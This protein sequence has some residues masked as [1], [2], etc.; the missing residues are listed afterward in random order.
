MSI[1]VDQIVTI[2]ISIVTGLG[3]GAVIIWALSSWLGKVWAN[4][5]LEKDRLRYS[6]ELEVVKTELGRAS[7]EYLIKF[8]SLHAERGTIIRDLYK[9]LMSAQ[10]LVESILKR[11]QAEGEPRLEDKIKDFVDSFNQFYQFYLDS[12]IYFPPHLC[13]QIED[14]AKKLREIHIDITLYPVSPEDIQ[15]KVAPEL[16]KE[17]REFWE[18]AR[19]TFA[20]EAEGLF[21][22]IEAEI[23]DLLGVE[24]K[25]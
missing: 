6:R 25:F 7:Q 9:K 22:S 13:K 11:F 16:L 12:R 5:I 1:T 20:T 19:D 15:Y 4:R 18:K 23:R 2:C 3:G 8:S 17:Q 14:F 24:K 10:R 21:G